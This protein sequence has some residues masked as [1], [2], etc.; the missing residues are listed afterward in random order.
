MPFMT[1]VKEW[2]IE[3]P[4]PHTVRVEHSWITGRVLLFLD[5]QEVFRRP[6]KFWDVGC[7]HPFACDGARGLLRV[8]CGYWLGMFE[9]QLWVDGKL[10]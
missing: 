6:R 8:F 10:Q 3:L 2:H 4:A 5:D 7:K 1:I 9:Y